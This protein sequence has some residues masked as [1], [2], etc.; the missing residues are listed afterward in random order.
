MG[1]LNSF[2]INPND[3]TKFI[4]VGQE[5]QITF[6]DANKTMADGMINS[7]PDPRDSD[8]LFYVTA[9]PDGRHFATGGSQGVLRV[10][11]FA[12]GKCVSEQKGHSST[13]SCVKFS[14]DG[15]QIVTTGTDGLVLVWNMFG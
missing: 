15:K 10:W 11:E 1:G 4:T 9:A 3:N 13:I 7:T 8:E 2:C 14:P 12:T 6:W 5:R